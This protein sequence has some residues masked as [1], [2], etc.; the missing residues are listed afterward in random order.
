MVPRSRSQIFL[1]FVSPPKYQDADERFS[2]SVHGKTDSRCAEANSNVQCIR[3]HYFSEGWLHDFEKP[4][5][6]QTNARQHHNA[7][8]TMAIEVR[9][10]QA[11]AARQWPKHPFWVDFSGLG[12]CQNQ[13][14][15]P[16]AVYTLYRSVL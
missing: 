15:P 8:Q 14:S 10:G 7:L 6:T 16:D 5:H 3:C 9:E 11:E 12:N 4:K 1:T 13:D 2:N